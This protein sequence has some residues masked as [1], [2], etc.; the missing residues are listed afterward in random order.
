M[1]EDLKSATGAR[2]SSFPENLAQ[3]GQFSLLRWF[4]VLSLLIISTVALSLGYI[5]TRFVV[6]ESVERDALLTA[7]F[8]HAIAA[9]EIRH[10]S[11]S[12]QYVMGDALDTRKI[13]RFPVKTVSAKLWARG[14]F[15]DHISHLPDVL[16][17][18]I[19]AAD[20]V[21][22][23]STNRDL[24]GRTILGNQEL[25]RAFTSQ[26]AVSASYHRVDGSRAEQRFTREPEHL[27]IE[28]YIPLFDQAGQGVMAMVEIYK[29]PRD[30]IE[31]I[32][33]G[34]QRIWIST[35]VGG[36]LT[37]VCLFWIVLRASR[38]LASQQEQLLTNESY[39]LLGEMSSTIAH[40]LRNPL[41]AIRSSAELAQET[42][43]VPAQR[44]IH[45]IIGQVDRMSSWLRHLL[46]SSSPLSSHSEAVDLHTC[47]HEVLSNFTQQMEQAGVT[48][49]LRES[50]VPP[51]LGNQVLLQ[52]VLHSLFANAIE[53]MPE[54]GAIDVETSSDGS[55][56][57]LVVKDTGKGMNK[58]QEAL[59]FKPFYSTKRG[60]LG[61]GLMLAK[62]IM[63]R[64]G[65][66]ITLKSQPQVGTVVSLT[67]TV[68]PGGK[69][70]TEY[71]AG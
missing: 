53:A 32:Q 31:R 68:A 62:R 36:A 27:F 57:Q 3:R 34:Y 14:E 7:Q 56:V 33:R 38:L 48:V 65:G 54:G 15:L 63:T 70:G 37:Y 12:P 22:I 28:N 55:K 16:L 9:A 40:N 58:E 19:Y 42:A 30:L 59:A 4:S 5:A 45:D 41:A 13:S 69:Y 67:F 66:S 24:V 23:W 49:N 35:A 8:I 60:G 44:N 26:G 2:R 25:E 39:V 6:N 52:Q 50:G 43:G 61:V 21:I 71:S 64:F 47:V 10:V 29:E 17:V 11:L 51:V 1:R 46:L 20:R 18:N